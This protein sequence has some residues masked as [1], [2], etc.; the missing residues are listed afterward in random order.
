VSHFLTV[1]AD[2]A[3]PPPPPPPPGGGLP[4][5]VMIAFGVGAMAAVSLLVFLWRRTPASPRTTPATR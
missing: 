1:F 4:P 3:V 5:L 2:I